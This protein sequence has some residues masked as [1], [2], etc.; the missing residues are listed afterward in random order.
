MPSQTRAQQCQAF[1]HV[2]DNV[3]E[4]GDESTLKIAL[5]S[6]GFETMNDLMCITMDQI[7]NLGYTTTSAYVVPL[8]QNLIRYL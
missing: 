8:D 7:V 4:H 5:I 1:N 3:L 6:S 2:L